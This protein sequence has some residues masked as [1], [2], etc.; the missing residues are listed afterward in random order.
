[1]RA[2]G[3][4]AAKNDFLSTVYR[5]NEQRSAS[6]DQRITVNEHRLTDNEYFSNHR[7]DSIAIFG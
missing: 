7:S 4:V 2:I 3:E 5:K 6:S 1:M